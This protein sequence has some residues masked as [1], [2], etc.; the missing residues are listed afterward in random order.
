M[1]KFLDD[2]A[3]QYSRLD[4]LN[5]L[6]GMFVLWWFDFVS[7]DFD[8]YWFTIMSDRVAVHFCGCWYRVGDKLCQV[9][10]RKPNVLAKHPQLC[11]S[12]FCAIFCCGMMFK[13]VFVV[14]ARS[15]VFLYT[16]FY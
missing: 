7:L 9:H 8:K 14:S 1:P 10:N 3:N 12:P 13:Q 4:N 2:A 15:N 16:L 11:V 6:F 5:Y